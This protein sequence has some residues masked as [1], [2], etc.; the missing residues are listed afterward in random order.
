MQP[1]ALGCLQALFAGC[2]GGAS[3]VIGKLAGCAA[4]GSAVD[5]A[6]KVCIYAGMILSNVGALLH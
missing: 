4:S 3:A 1:V 5:I 6:I 2:L